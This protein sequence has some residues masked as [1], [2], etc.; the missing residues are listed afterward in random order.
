MFGHYLFRRRQH[1]SDII[2]GRLEVRVEVESK[3]SGEIQVF[4]A[5]Q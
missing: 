1:N 4:V 3:N 2:G 5:R